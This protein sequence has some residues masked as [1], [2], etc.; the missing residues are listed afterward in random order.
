MLKGWLLSV[1]K[2]LKKWKLI[3]SGMP[4]CCCPA[5]EPSLIADP[6]MFIELL[7]ST[8]LWKG[9]S[10]RKCRWLTGP[11]PTSEGQLLIS[12]AFVRKTVLFLWCDK[13]L[14]FSNMLWEYLCMSVLF[15]LSVT[16]LLIL[17]T[18]FGWSLLT[19]SLMIF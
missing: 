8:V 17:V 2:K 10:S 1:H 19:C 5:Q 15:L 11:A 16:G 14:V 12:L 9:W 4:S 13:I 3:L 7:V 6:V 18:G